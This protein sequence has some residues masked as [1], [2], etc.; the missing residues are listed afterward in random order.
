MQINQLIPTLNENGIDVEVYNDLILI[1]QELHIKEIHDH[2]LVLSSQMLADA[3]AKIA[4][5]INKMP[6]GILVSYYNKHIS[7]PEFGMTYKC[8]HLTPELMCLNIVAHSKT[9]A[10]SLTSLAESTKQ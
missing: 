5:G 9:L 4:Y 8:M 7:R 10:K 3:G 2:V 6:D 1:E